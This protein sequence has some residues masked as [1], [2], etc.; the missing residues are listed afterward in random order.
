MQS[1]LII[2]FLSIS[3]TNYIRG[4]SYKTN[5]F[6]AKLDVKKYFS[7]NYKIVEIRNYLDKHV[8]TCTATNRLVNNL[9]ISVYT[10]FLM[11]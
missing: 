4:N 11:G 2:M 1:A 8:F 3:Q 5:K 6:N 9:K 7:H 10:I